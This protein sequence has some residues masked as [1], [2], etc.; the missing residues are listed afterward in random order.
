M[1]ALV[2]KTAPAAEP[3]SVADFRTHA[4]LD[5]NGDDD[6]ITAKLVA[7]RQWAEDYTNRRFINATWTMILDAWPGGA[8]L[9][10]LPVAPIVSI[11]EVRTLS[12]DYTSAVVSSSTYRLIH[13]EIV[14]LSTWPA[15]GASIGGIEIDFVA[16][17]G[18][19][20]AAVPYAIRQAILK[21]AA[22][23]YENREAAIDAQVARRELSPYRLL[24]LT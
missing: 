2:L 24:E 7:A 20:A 11:S 13:R 3:V 5:D 10:R 9:V 6:D 16:G 21:V 23:Q 4:R 22:H 19:A 1:R 17:Y 8:G 14:P 12:A 18:D 15:P